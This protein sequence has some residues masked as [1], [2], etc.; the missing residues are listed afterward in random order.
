MGHPAQ[1][2]KNM[3]AIQEKQE[4]RVRSLGREER[5]KCQPTPAFLLGK[6]HGQESLAGYRLWCHKELDMTV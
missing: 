5:K 4:T 6:S 3:P 2:V 1:V